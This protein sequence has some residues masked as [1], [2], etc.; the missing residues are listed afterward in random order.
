RDRRGGTTMTTTTT[1][2][3]MIATARE[4]RP[5]IESYSGEA[6][7]LRRLPDG[8]VRLFRDQGIFGMARPAKYAGMGLDLMTTMRVVE[9]VS[10]A[11]AS[12]G[13][14]AAIGSGSIGT[15]QL[16]DDVARQIYKPGVP[17]AGVGSPTGRAVPVAGGYRIS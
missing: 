13:W 15:L 14:C 6:E 2:R 12:A 9:E 1:V 16:R 5:E 17:L 7:A 4:L 10:I 8:L 3:D 11:D